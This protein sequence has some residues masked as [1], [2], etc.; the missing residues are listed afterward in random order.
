MR[1][2]RHGGRLLSLAML[3]ASL[4][5][6][7]MNGG[8]VSAANVHGS[9]TVKPKAGVVTSSPGGKPSPST[10]ATNNSDSATVKPNSGDKPSHPTQATN[11]SCSHVADEFLQLFV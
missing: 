7:L 9:A 3:G 6:V 8:G 2:F 10:Q 4:G 1:L 5:A 11:N